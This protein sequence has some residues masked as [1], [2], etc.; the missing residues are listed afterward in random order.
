MAYSAEIAAAM[1][2]KQQANAIIQARQQVV[3]GALGICK[4]TINQ[5]KGE[6]CDLTPNGQEQ[7]INTML[8]TL[9]SD[10][11]VSPVLTVGGA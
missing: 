6:I 3:K 4:D 11:N 9:V 7:L 10:K 1:L 2:M 8:A 5:I